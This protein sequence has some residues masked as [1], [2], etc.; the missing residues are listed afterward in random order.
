VGR[1]GDRA[2]TR[3]RP[4]RRPPAAAAAAAGR[5]GPALPPSAG[6]AAAD[7]AAAVN[8]RS[9]S[10]EVQVERDQKTRDQRCIYPS[11]WVA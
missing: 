4:E 8:D 11:P 1:R 7:A 3:P 5:T 6:S 9:A 2:A 10:C